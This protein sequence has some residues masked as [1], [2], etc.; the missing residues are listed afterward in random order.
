MI[1][2]HRLRQFSVLVR[3]GN[4]TRASQELNM[5]Q[6]ALSRSIQALEEHLGTRLLDRERGKTGV[7]LTLAGTDLYERAED[8]L[9]QLDDLESSVSGVAERPVRRLRLGIGPMLGAALLPTLLQRRL[10]SEPNL[11]ISVCTTTSDLMTSLLLD[12]DIEFYL[13]LA[14]LKYRP[15]RMRQSVFATFQPNFYVRPGHPLAGR[16]TLSSHDLSAF[17]RISGTAW[18]ENLISL[19]NER[20]R[21]LFSTTM[22]VDNYEILAEIARNSSAILISSLMRAEEGLVRLPVSLELAAPYSELHIFSLAGAR[23]SHA[24]ES[25]IEELRAEYLAA[26][27][28]PDQI[29]PSPQLPQRQRRESEREHDPQ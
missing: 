18:D 22:Q 17:P 27:T 15:T 23:L 12:G 29:F 26:T 11:A 21:Y 6:S 14:P 13:G 20:D 28:A 3:V 7:S 24:A 8:L 25:F 19:G 16:E 4:F 5:T 2:M 9:A 10:G 1:D